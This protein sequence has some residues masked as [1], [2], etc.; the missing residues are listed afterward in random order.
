MTHRHFYRLS[1]VVVSGSIWVL[2]CQDRDCPCC[3]VFR[4]WPPK[5]GRSRTVREFSTKA[6]EVATSPL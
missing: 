4:G 3:C 5:G 6:E 2:A 1:R